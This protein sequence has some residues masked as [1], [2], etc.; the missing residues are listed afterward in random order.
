MTTCVIILFLFYYFPAVWLAAYC[1]RPKPPPP[2]SPSPLT[3]QFPQIFSLPGFSRN[4]LHLTV[5]YPLHCFH[6]LGER[7]SNNVSSASSY[8]IFVWW[9]LIIFTFFIKKL[10]ASWTRRKKGSGNGK[11]Q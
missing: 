1:P 8:H 6:D 9:F 7:S 4:F 3:K 5:L 10:Q 11:A 2:S